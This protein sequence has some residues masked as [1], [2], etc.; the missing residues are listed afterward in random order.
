MIQNYIRTAWRQ[1]G[2]NRF[3]SL[4]NISGLAVGVAAC[5]LIVLFVL[6][7]TSYDAWNPQAGRIV[8]P[9]YHIK[10]KSFEEK[11]GCVDAAVGPETAASLPN[12]TGTTDH[13]L[14]HRSQ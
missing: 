6:Y 10:I 5:L 7:E 12:Y 9:V 2:K 1:L 8:R 13:C 11:H 4:L 14:W 3:Y